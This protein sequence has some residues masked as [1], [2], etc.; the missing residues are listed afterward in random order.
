MGMQPGDP[1]IDITTNQSFDGRIRDIPD[2]VPGGAAAGLWRGSMMT[3]F[4]TGAPKGK[5][6]T[7]SFLYNPSVVQ[8]S[9]SLNTDNTPMPAYTRSDAD[10]GTPMVAAGGSLSFSLLFDRTYEMSDRSY[11]GTHAGE[12]GVGADIQ[13]LYNMTGVNTP[14]VPLNRI[15]GEETDRPEYA[16]SVVGTMQMN[17]VWIRFGQTNATMAKAV[18]FMTRLVYFGYINSLGISYT[19]FTHRMIPVRCAVSVSVQL[20]STTGWS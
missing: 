19:H 16:K 2:Y 10:G 1:G 4:Q 20:M 8:V 9:H 13:V 3:A 6:Y 12:L 15:G 14:L 7:L 11:S 5:F 17:P 18:P